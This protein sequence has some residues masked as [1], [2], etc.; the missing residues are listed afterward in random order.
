MPYDIL[1][2]APA[3]APAVL[4]L[5]RLAYQAEALRYNDWNLPP[6]TQPLEALEA[7]FKRLVILKAVPAEE[8]ADGPTTWDADS[9][10][11][12]VVGSVRAGMSHGV[13]HIGRLIVHPDHQRQGLG[14][15]LLAA[16]EA[17]F[18]KAER[19]SL[20]TGARS[21]D[22]VRL[23]ERRGYSVVRRQELTPELTL[24][25]LE[26]PGPAAR[27]NVPGGQEA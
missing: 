18:P 20:F 6:L 12:P 3:D 16:I 23:Y 26:K 9:I 13:C 1:P 8:P 5:Q 19:Y 27:Q 15:A 7:E 2:A 14:S 24:V 17:R 11:P 4:A 22:N 10:A 21:E 25:F